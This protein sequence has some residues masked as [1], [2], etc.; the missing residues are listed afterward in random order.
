MLLLQGELLGFLVMLLP[1]VFL[2]ASAGVML[3]GDQSEFFVNLVRV[4]VCACVVGWVGG[5][6][7]G[8]VSGWVGGRVLE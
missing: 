6:V 8:R 2:W 3:F 7:G 1:I 4:C 5:W